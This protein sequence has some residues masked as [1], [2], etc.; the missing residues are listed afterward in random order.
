MHPTNSSLKYSASNGSCVENF[1]TDDAE[2]A[3]CPKTE[4]LRI[5]PSSISC[6]NNTTANNHSTLCQKSY[7]NTSQFSL[8]ISVDESKTLSTS[9]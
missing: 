1:S 3:L 4:Y 5:L 9:K 8:S 7:I 2:E 6:Q